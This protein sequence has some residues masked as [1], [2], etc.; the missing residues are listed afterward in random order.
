M[1]D[2]ITDPVSSMKIEITARK[3]QSGMEEGLF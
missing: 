3:I 2:R 1:I